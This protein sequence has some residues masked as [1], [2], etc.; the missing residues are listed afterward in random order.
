MQR[1]IFFILYLIIFCPQTTVA[2]AAEEAPEVVAA[3]KARDHASVAELQKLVA[4]AEKA[5]A[6]KQS[7]EPYLRLALFNVWLCEAIESHQDDKLFKQAA[8]AGVAAAEKAVTLDPNS[9]DAHQLL[10]D[11]L[12][13]LIPHVYGGGMRYGK[14]ATDELDRAIELNPKNINAYVSRAISYYYSPDSFGG[15]K[16]KAFELLNKAVE[17][18]P[19]QDAAHIWL[20]IFDLD[21]GQMD[22]AQREINLALKADPERAFTRYVNSQIT[23]AKRSAAH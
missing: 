10:G 6:A 16:P 2:L 11:L 4:A 7:L 20:A 22:N 12:S 9:S 1:F 3:R 15:S 13:Q 21:A 8:E 14:R 19:A 18:E 23:A 5:A 17:L